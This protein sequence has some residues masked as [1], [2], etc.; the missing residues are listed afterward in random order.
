MVCTTDALGET[1]ST[2]DLALVPHRLALAE[3]M[4]LNST[5]CHQTVAAHLSHQDAHGLG[6]VTDLF[7]LS[8][9]PVL[10]FFS[11]PV[12]AARA[13]AFDKFGQFA[14]EADARGRLDVF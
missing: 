10:Y 13:A 8:V 4:F 12:A 11:P 1:T 9:D 5:A 14:A 3:P 7:E 6:G 2:L